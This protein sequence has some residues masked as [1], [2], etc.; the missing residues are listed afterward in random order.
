MT[1]PKSLTTVTTFSKILAMF[2]FLLLPFAGFYAGYKYRE[3]TN[4]NFQTIQQIQT[5]TIAPVSNETSD[6]KTFSSRYIGALSI[7]KPSDPSKF[8]IEYSFKYPPDY[9]VLDGYIVTNDSNVGYN[10]TPSTPGRIAVMA[11]ASIIDSSVLRDRLY[12]V[13]FRK[14]YDSPNKSVIV[15]TMPA[16]FSTDDLRVDFEFMCSF[17]PKNNVDSVK[18]CDLMASTLK[19]TQ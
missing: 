15:Y 5:P 12:K 17:F 9:K 2:L 13:Q 8:S 18:I 19:F 1:L 6:W 14:V 3:G 7:S 4:P 16:K 10:L 11:S